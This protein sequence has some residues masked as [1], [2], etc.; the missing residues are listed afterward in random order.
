MN[1]LLVSTSQKVMK[2]QQY[3]RL[4][5]ADSGKDNPNSRKAAIVSQIPAEKAFQFEK[6]GIF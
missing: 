2:F 1:R 4:W 3:P 5:K 6:T